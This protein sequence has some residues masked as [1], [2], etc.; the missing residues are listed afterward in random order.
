MKKSRILGYALTLAATLVVGGAMGQTNNTDNAN[1]VKTGTDA[2]Q[3]DGKD[4]NNKSFITV[5]KKLGFFVQPDMAFHPTWT[6]AQSWKLTPDFSWKWSVFAGSPEAASSDIKFNNAGVGAATYTGTA[7]NPATVN[8][9]ANFVELTPTKT[10]VYTIKVAEKASTAFGGC[11]GGLKSF[12]LIVM[13]QPNITVNTD[14][15]APDLTNAPTTGGT[16]NRPLTAVGCGDLTNWN[17]K[18]TIS[19]ADYI[20]AKIRLEQFTVKI[21]AVTGKVLVGNGATIDGGGNPVEGT[22]RTTY[23]YIVKNQSVGTTEGDAT[24]DLTT[25]IPSITDWDAAWKMKSASAFDFASST[26]NR[27]D[28]SLNHTRNFAVYTDPTPANSDIMTLYRYTVLGVN[29][30]VSRKSDGVVY[31]ASSKPLGALYGESKTGDVKVVDIYVKKAPTTGPVYHIN[32]N[33]AK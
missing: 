11:E 24:L 10:G 31:T 1:Y 33:V 6:S 22:A 23:D 14:A 3:V 30:F 8:D 7:T 25:A 21:D 5:N 20:N 19:A 4:V 16:N 13:A 12:N 28:I 27:T 15:P 9:P 2:V 17:V 32:N 26:Q 29:D 18:F